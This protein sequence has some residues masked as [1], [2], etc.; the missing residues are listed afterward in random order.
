MSQALST[1]AR[2]KRLLKALRAQ[3]AL[4]ERVEA[5]MALTQVESAAAGGTADEIED[6]VAEGV[7]HLGR[8]VIR[9]WAQAAESQVAAALRR[10]QP[11][12]R[13]REKKA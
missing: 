10:A 4:L 8:E 12:A 3:P 5:L 11:Q 1:A 9:G 2:E 13:V 6:Q 7:R